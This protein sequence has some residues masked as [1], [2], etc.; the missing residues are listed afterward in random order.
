MQEFV[1][2]F[3]YIDDDGDRATA[4]TKP[5]KAESEEKAIERLKELWQIEFETR[6]DILKVKVV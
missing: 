2:V 5:F 1:I 6:I 4:T 3:T